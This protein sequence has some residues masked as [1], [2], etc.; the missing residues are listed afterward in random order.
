[1]NG[2]PNGDCRYMLPKGITAVPDV[3]CDVSFKSDVIKTTAEFHKSLSASANIRGGGWG[4]EFS[5]S[6]SYQKSSSDMSSREYVYVISRAKCTAYFSRMEVSTPPPFDEGFLAKARGLASSSV[7]DADVN[8]FIETYGT[9]FLD[10]VTFGSSYTHEHRMTT[11]TYKTLSSSKFGVAVQ[12]SYSGMFSVGGGFS[13]DTEQTQ[14][15][16]K[17]SKSV[18]T[19]TVTV[20]S[21][22]P[23]NGDAMTWASA[24]K[25]NPVPVSYRLRPIEELFTARYFGSNSNIN[26][27]SI[28]TKLQNAPRKSCALLKSKGVAVTCTSPRNYGTTQ[29]VTLNG[30][31]PRLP[32]GVTEFVNTFYL[33]PSQT[34]CEL[35]CSVDSGCVGYTS[36]LRDKCSIIKDGKEYEWSDS[37]SESFTLYFNKLVSD[38]IVKTKVPKA[39]DTSQSPSKRLYAYYQFMYAQDTKQKN[40]QDCRKLCVRDPKCLAFRFGRCHTGLA[41]CND[42]ICYIYHNISNLKSIK[43]TD[44]EFHFVA[45]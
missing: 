32:S 7:S 3:S 45:K 35:M 19:S 27:N 34:D 44:T 22:P 23:G 1:M 36:A 15:A 18:E 13:L 37:N 24:S 12:A 29:V 20:G 14:A 42:R 40:L 17:F 8:K 10:E 9:H 30:G 38:L 43:L 21:A 39:V 26:Y 25:E 33:T 41:L 11:S 4:F 16:S 6:S 31:Y 5:A 28:K 2:K